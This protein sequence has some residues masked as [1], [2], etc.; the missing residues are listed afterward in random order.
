MNNLYSSY[1]IKIINRYLSDILIRKLIKQYPNKF[2]KIS[3]SHKNFY[4]ILTN[5]NDILFKNNDDA[6]LNDLKNKLNI[7]NLIFELSEKEKKIEIDKFINN[8]KDDNTIIIKEPISI[9]N[10]TFSIK[11]LNFLVE[12]LFYCKSQG[13]ILVHPNI[14]SKE[15]IQLKNIKEIIPQTNDFNSGNNLNS[16][17]NIPFIPSEDGQL[18]ETDNEKNIK[19][20]IIYETNLIKNELLK[21]FHKSIIKKNINIVDISNCILKNDYTNLYLVNSSFTRGLSLELNSPI[22]NF[23]KDIVFHS[24]DYND[25]ENNIK[26]LEKILK[27]LK[28]DEKYIKSFHIE[29][30]EYIYKNIKDYCK[31]LFKEECQKIEGT[32]IIQYQSNYITIIKRLNRDIMNNLEIENIDPYE[33]KAL[34]TAIIIPEII[35]IELKNLNILKEKIS[36]SVEEFYVKQN[37]EK[38]L[39]IIFKAIENKVKLKNVNQDLIGEVKDFI[40]EQKLE[41]SDELYS[42]NISKEK[43]ND[44]II[45]IFGGNDLNWLKNENSKIIIKIRIIICESSIS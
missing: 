27:D 15:K 29:I 34:I 41:N 40:K 35:C 11:E 13:T 23:V 33:I 37:I 38:I 32:E 14:K 22:A 7:N 18:F 1:L 42:L 17:N 20:T 28:E 8:I 26:K 6:I 31:N 21:D 39:E 3:I 9:A 43:I 10:E 19:N 16:S 12:T 4:D 45:K 36:K 24:S 25:A 44:M 2:A 30:N 5:Y